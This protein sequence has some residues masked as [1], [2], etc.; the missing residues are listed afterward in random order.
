MHHGFG[1]LTLASPSAQDLLG[2]EQPRELAHRIEQLPEA[3]LEQTHAKMT[4]KAIKGCSPAAKIE[5]QR[6]T[7]SDQTHLCSSNAG[8]RCG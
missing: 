2:K 4:V 3:V 7:S 6:R 8:F 5:R 1:V